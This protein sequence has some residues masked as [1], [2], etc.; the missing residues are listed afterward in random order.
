MK[1]TQIDLPPRGRLIEVNGFYCVRFGER[2]FGDW[3][4]AER[5]AVKLAWDEWEASSGITKDQLRGMLGA[6]EFV[7]DF[8][9]YEAEMEPSHRSNAYDE[10]VDILNSLKG[11]IDDSTLQVL[12]DV[13]QQHQGTCDKKTAV[14]KSESREKAALHIIEMKQQEAD[15]GLYPPV[16]SAILGQIRSA[17]AGEKGGA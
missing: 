11:I 16:V 14:N 1:G 12:R 8:A 3:A 15:A 4:N 17:L 13:E 2:E 10:A 6:A 9:R 7:Q 5:K